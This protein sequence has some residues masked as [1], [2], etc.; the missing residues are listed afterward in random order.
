MKKYLISILDVR[1]NLEEIINLGIKLKNKSKNK[2][3]IEILK[4]KIL[5]MIFEKASTRTRISFE[6]AEKRMGASTINF[7][8]AL[9]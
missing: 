4:G 7:N 3:S 1:D 5:G 6:V 9:V 8:V 2:E